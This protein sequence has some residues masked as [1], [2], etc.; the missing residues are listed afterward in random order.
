MRR[1]IALFA[2]L[3]LSAPVVLSA[4]DSN[5][6]KHDRKEVRHDRRELRG[7][8]KDI[9][10]DTK[11]IREDRREV[12]QDLKNGRIAATGATTCAMHTG[13]A[14]IYGRIGRTSTRT[15]RKTARRNEDRPY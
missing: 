7:D 11:D 4:Q 9:R 10:H 1:H 12:R 2:V 15:R 8:R 5:D 6:V 14:R 13:I 3:A